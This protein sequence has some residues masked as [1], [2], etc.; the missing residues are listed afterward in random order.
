MM[1]LDFLTCETEI[2]KDRK[3]FHL[4]VKPIGATCNLRCTYCYYLEKSNL[5]PQHQH[6][7]RMSDEVLELYI[8]NYIASQPTENPRVVFAWQG[9]EP[10]LLGVDF[11]ERAIE[12]QQKY[13]DG[14]RIENTLQTNGML[15]DEQWVR[16]F[17]AH[18]FL[19]GISI[20]GPQE[21]HDAY[22]KNQLGKGS[23]KR[24]MQS[25]SLLKKGGVRF[26]TLTVVNRLNAQYPIRVYKFL[27][28]IG[29]EWIQFI[30]IQERKATDKNQLLQLVANDYKE[31]AVVTQESILPKQWGDFLIQIFDHWVREDVG[32]VFVKQ[33]DCALEAWC[34]YNPTACVLSRSCGDGLVMEHNGDVYACDHFVYPQFKLGNIKEQSLQQMALSAE[35]SQ[36]GKEKYEGLS[37]QCRNC[38]YLAACNGECPKHRFAI[39]AEGEKIAYLCQGYYAFF[40]YAAPFLHAMRTLIKQGGEASSIMNFLAVDK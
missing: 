16:F 21:L 13:S 27:K 10:T 2:N 33:F 3:H 29:S 39:N 38:K 20:D 37:A 40:D 4:I 11:F 36:F 18:N 15:I 34:G 26:N 14:R 31:E 35:Q 24:V 32:K 8:K 28:E 23:W 1:N 12:L 17:K 6:Q 25:I 19:I 22:R 7:Y 5:Y 9:G 30:P